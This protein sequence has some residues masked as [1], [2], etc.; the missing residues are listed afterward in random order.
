MPEIKAYL[1][2]HNISYASNA[3]KADLLNLAK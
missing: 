2:S 1:D 3:S